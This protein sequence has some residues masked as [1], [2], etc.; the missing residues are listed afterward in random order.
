MKEFLFLVK[1]YTES[2]KPIVHFKQGECHNF[3]PSV[4]CGPISIAK[5]EKDLKFIPVPLVS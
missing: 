4:E 3:L 2:D 1:K 5:I